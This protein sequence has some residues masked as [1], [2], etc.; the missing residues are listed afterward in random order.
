MRVMKSRAVRE[1]CAVLL[2]SVMMFAGATP[3]AAQGESTPGGRL[4]TAPTEVAQGIPVAPGFLFELE[5]APESLKEI[6]IWNEIEKMLDQP[7][8]F[9]SSPVEGNPQ[10]WPSYRSTLP[11]RRSYLPAG[12]DYNP[13]TAPPRATTPS[14][15]RS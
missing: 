3:G 13:A 15:S 2:S 4:I 5:N 6:P 8:A 7:Y 9:T 11:R 10:G 1:L 14:S 12:C